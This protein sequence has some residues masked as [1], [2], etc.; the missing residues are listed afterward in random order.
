MSA[1]PDTVVAFWREAGPA[2]WFARSDAFDAQIRTR[3]EAL[4]HTA[5]RGEL[6]GWAFDAEGALALVLLLDQFPRNL[7]RGSAHSWATDGKARAVADT[8]IAAGHDVQVE[9][10]L[11]VFFYMPFEHSEDPADQRRAVALIEALCGRLGDRTLM[12]WAVLHHDLI[13]RFGRF[14][15]RNAALGRRTT[16]QEQAF[17]DGGGFAG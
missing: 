8:A 2:R 11:Q 3:F 9:P 17:L 12:K 6:D 4:H 1:T 14:P 5:A 13:E 10:S 7:Y 15:H 16:A